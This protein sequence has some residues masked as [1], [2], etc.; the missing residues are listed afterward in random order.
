MPYFDD[1]PDWIYTPPAC[2]ICNS[3]NFEV[4]YN[5][6]RYAPSGEEWSVSFKCNKC[7]WDIEY[8]GTKSDLDYYADFY[9]ITG[10]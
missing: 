4:E 1:V 9:K 6:N 8:N 3:D 10:I 2:P 7:K 5:Y